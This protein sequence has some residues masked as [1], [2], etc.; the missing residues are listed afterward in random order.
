MFP[1]F[2]KHLILEPYYFLLVQRIRAAEA[3]LPRPSGVRANAS[4]AYQESF[5]CFRV[6]RDLNDLFAFAHP[7]IFPSSSETS[8]KPY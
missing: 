3:L 2:D 6:L 5:S 8:L 4:R 1:R 7:F